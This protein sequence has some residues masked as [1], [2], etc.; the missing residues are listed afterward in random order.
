MDRYIV[1]ASCSVIFA[2][3]DTDKVAETSAIKE[4][5]WKRSRHC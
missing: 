4:T 2:I 1:I 3:Q 5:V